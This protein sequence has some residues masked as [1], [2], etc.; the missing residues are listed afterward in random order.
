[1]SISGIFLALAFMAIL[2]TII[3]WPLMTQHG[4]EGSPRLKSDRAALETQY[5]A[6][7]MSL[8]DLDF[9]FQTGKLTDTDYH[10]QRDHQMARAAELLKLL[11]KH[12]P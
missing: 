7:L 3:V 12:T 8:G 10:R 5:A 6:L 1:M 11:D 9:D 2:V 4:S